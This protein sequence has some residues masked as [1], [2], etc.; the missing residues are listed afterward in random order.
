MKHLYLILLASAL[1]LG[2]AAQ[3]KVV[4]PPVI[5]DNMV[6]QQNTDA[7]IFGKAEPGKTVTVRTSWN[8]K[9]V[10]ATADPE[11]GRWLVRVATPS[12]GGPY[13][14]TISDG[15]KLTLHNVLIGEVW[16]ASG[17]SNMEMPVKGYSSQPARDGVKYIIGAKRSRPIRICN[18]SKQS[19][20]TVKDSCAGTWN[21]HTPDEVART[22]ATAYFFADALQ[23]ALDVPVGIIVSSWGGSSIETWLKREVFESQ[24]PSVDLGHLD[25]KRAVRSNHKDPCLLYNGQV[26]PLVPFTFKGMIWY[27]GEAN[28][29]HPELYAAYQKAYVEMM[30][31][32]FAVPDAPFYFVQIAPYPYDNARKTH[33]GYFYEAQAASLK[34]IPHSG[35]ATTCDVGE[36][37]TI[38]PCRKQEVGQRLAMLALQHD[39]GFT[40]IEADAPSYR[41]AEIKEGKVHLHFTVDRN[42]LSPMG[43][44]LTGFEIAGADRKFVPASARRD[45]KRGDTVIVWSDSVPEP[46]AVRYCFR[47]WSEGNLYNNFGVPAAPFRTDDWPLNPKDWEE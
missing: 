7:A 36:Y 29:P 46:V 22:S 40:A 21:E 6:L 42:G 25:G 19:S 3:A 15:D 16:F 35:M 24:F 23:N 13:E 20:T 45:S 12:A 28:R 38:H 4:L 18:I 14:I 30:R 32:D 26:A 10:S 47:N 39:Y 17:Q 5:S 2:S 1:L 37:G 44:D 43:A 31:S 11:T 41:N 27:Q 9:K 8:K 34:I 33:Q